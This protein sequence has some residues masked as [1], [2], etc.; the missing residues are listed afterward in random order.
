MR[1]CLRGI[2]ESFLGIHS[3][4]GLL[5][6]VARGPGLRLA[7]CGHGFARGATICVNCAT[8]CP[9][10]TAEAVSEGG[11]EYRDNPLGIREEL[12]MPQ[13]MSAK[14]AIAACTLALGGVAIYFCVQGV[15]SDWTMRFFPTTDLE[16]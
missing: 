10:A 3:D 11:V 9:V 16:A 5:T 2:K 13:A 8:V 1:K 6:S 4:G 7:G 14:I 15:G 12:C